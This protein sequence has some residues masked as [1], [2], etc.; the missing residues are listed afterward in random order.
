MRKPGTRQYTYADFFL[1]FTT[2]Q[3]LFWVSESK[4]TSALGE[5][6]GSFL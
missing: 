5:V 3:F 2:Q 6:F 4:K 1:A